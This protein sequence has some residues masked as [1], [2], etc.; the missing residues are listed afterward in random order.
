VPLLSPSTQPRGN[1]PQSPPCLTPSRGAVGCPQCRRPPGAPRSFCL[2][3]FCSLQVSSRKKRARER[4]S[5]KLMASRIC[6]EPHHSC[7]PIFL[8]RKS[9][10]ASGAGVRYPLPG[11]H[12]P[13]SLT[14]VILGGPC[15]TR[16]F[17]RS[18]LFLR[19]IRNSFQ[20]P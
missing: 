5:P 19:Q 16:H 10:H 2:P 17:L 7:A 1:P 8:Q 12:F 14:A 9:P 20:I 6:I 13:V 11:L 3:L 15:S 18:F 4:V